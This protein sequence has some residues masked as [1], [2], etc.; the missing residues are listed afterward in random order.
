MT[1]LPET[2]LTVIPSPAAG[3]EIPAPNGAM[4][5][6]CKE[7]STSSLAASIFAR[8]ELFEACRHASA[9]LPNERAGRQGFDSKI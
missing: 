9:D 7:D 2:E 8:V 5:E 4:T 3:T 6:M 1:M